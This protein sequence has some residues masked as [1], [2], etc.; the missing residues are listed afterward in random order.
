MTQSILELDNHNT[1]KKYFM[2]WNATKKFYSLSRKIISVDGTFVSDPNKGTL[3][4]A[5]AQDRKDQLVLLAFA[6]V[7][8][9]NLDSWSFFIRNFNIHF[10]INVNDHLIISDRGHGLILSIRNILPNIV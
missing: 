1:F 2:T 7:E 8:S 3:L 9:E 4:I 10:N 5:V 6:I